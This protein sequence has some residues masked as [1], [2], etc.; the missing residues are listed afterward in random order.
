MGKAKRMQSRTISFH[1]QWWELARAQ[2]PWQIQAAGSSCFL[3]L[4]SEVLSITQL[5][6]LR[7][8]GGWLAQV[9]WI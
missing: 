6:I 5:N 8:G 2:E 3:H 9:E 1:I 7:E 4:F